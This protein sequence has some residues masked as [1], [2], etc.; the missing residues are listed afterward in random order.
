LHV[1]DPKEQCLLSAVY[2]NRFEPAV[3]I[4]SVRQNVAKLWKA[5][6]SVL[7]QSELTHGHAMKTRKLVLG[8]VGLL[9]LVLSACANPSSSSTAT[10]APMW[11]NQFNQ[12]LA[13]PN[14]SDFE[15]QVLSDYKI[16]DAEYQ[17]AK[18][19]FVTCMTDKGWTVTYSNDG[20]Y[21]TVPAL[22]TTHTDPGAS[23]LDGYACSIGTTNWIEP[24]YLGIRNNPQGITREQQIR[25]CYE[26]H[27][28]PDGAGLSDDEFAHLVDDVNYHASTPEGILCYQDPTGSL[29]YTIEQAE[30]MDAATRS[31]VSVGPDGVSTVAVST[32]RPTE[33]RHS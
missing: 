27:N 15:R 25:T 29:G 9:V 18:D 31:R 7:T 10:L 33:T 6:K 1:A 17:E 28:V 19:R 22:G 4:P 2:L 32:P 8:V 16:T 26:Q 12:A 24:I 23:I 21:S 3:D 14:L 11:V 30:Q 13:D 20:G 5:T